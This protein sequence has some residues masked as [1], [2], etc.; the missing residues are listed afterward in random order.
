MSAAA[1]ARLAV[2]ALFGIVVI[3]VSWWALALWPVD[4]DAPE[5]FLRTREVC[6]GS[7][8]DSLPNAVGW[9]LL[10]GQPAGMV[11]LLAVVWSQELRAGMALLTSRFAGQVAV[12]AV[13]ALLVVGLGAT[14]NRVRTAGQ[15]PFST[16][17]A[18][19]LERQL[20]RISDPAPRLALTAQTGRDVSLD[21]FRGRPVIVT[22]AFAHCETVCPVLVQDVLKAARSRADE[23]SPAVLVV[24]LDPWRDTPS[25]LPSM[26]RAWGLQGD[27][28]V[29]SGAPETV[30]RTLNAWRI[31]RT[32]NQ[33][34]GDIIH[35]TVV[36][37][38]DAWGRITYAV[39]GDAD[40]IAAALRAL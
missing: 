31:P 13:S 38:I 5:W 35:P 23:P 39:N 25:R 1:R 22:F 21:S 34:N 28:Y 6:F 2:G 40:V 33:K 30:E 16:G 9:L 29:L 19:D 20:T 14:S 17:A 4:A 32:R 8:A 26:A 18:V 27:A 10:V 12:G 3:T 15:E 36:Y 11:L 7:T 24:T 37:V